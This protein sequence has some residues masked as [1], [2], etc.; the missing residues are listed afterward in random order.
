MKVLIIG[1]GGREHTIAWKI[2]QSDKVSEVFIAP[3]NAGTASIGTNVDISAD[4][5]DKLLSFAMDNDIDMTVVGP[6]GPLV[7]GIVDIFREK[8]LR[9]IG[10]DKKGARLEGSKAYA[11]RFMDRYNMPTAK[12][13]EYIDY[14][15]AL[16]GLDR[17]G[18]PVVIK[19]D[20][21]AAGKGVLIPENME[22]AKAALNT[23]MKDQ[24]FGDAGNKV[25]IEEFL[26]GI[27]ASMICFVDNETIVPMVSAKDYKR[28]LDGDKGLNTGGMGTF[29]PNTIVTDMLQEK[30]ND[31]V[32]KP[33]M[34]GIKKEEM[35]FRG[36]L[37][38]GLM[39][40]GDDIK[41]LEFNT[42][43]GDPETQVILPRLKSDL[44]NIFDGIIDDDL[45]S[46]D[47]SWSDKKAV[48]VVATSGG[49]PESYP[50]EKMI[51]IDNNILSKEDLFVFHAGT[52]L[53]GKD[54]LT[55]GGRVL[56]V[57]ALEESLDS[58]RKKSYKAMKS[59]SFEG[60]TFRNDIG[61][62]MK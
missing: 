57:V 27:E 40:D 44:Y 6:E 54:V 9:V 19:A 13:E 32:L 16:K 37:F 29:S 17:F 15:S 24:R 2:K 14:D 43:F 59:I 47:I 52:K 51:S 55:N 12:Y 50:K 41:I 39:I 8:G 62:D 34:E 61:L 53:S 5:I 38:V 11:K 3:G 48:C 60:L 33:F 30:I 31:Q 23:I 28:A 42:R 46:K 18:F 56:G 21:L 20:G 35:D 7:A 49:Y 10:P 26:T 36:I 22:E 45:K 1:S 25:V 4:D 58:A